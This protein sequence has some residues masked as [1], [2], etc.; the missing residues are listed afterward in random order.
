MKNSF[1]VY[2][3]KLANN[4]QKTFNSKPTVSYTEKIDKEFFVSD[5]D[6]DGYVEWQPIEVVEK[7]DWTQ[8]ET[9]LGFNLSKDLKEYYSSYLFL[10]LQGDIDN[11]TLNFYPLENKNEI[12][13]VIYQHFIDGQWAFKDSQHFLLLTWY[14]SR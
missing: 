14:L 10:E 13:N 7:K 12:D 11:I 3:K 1:N 8:I 6:S 4:Y 9:K 5:V 2:F